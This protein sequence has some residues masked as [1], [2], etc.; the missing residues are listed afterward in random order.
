VAPGD[1]STAPMSGLLAPPPGLTPIGAGGL[2]M[3]PALLP[4][5]AT[6]PPPPGDMPAITFD[7]SGAHTPEIEATADKKAKEK[8]RAAMLI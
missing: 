3:P 2:L 4:L 1:L 7:M 6:P 8:T 5:S